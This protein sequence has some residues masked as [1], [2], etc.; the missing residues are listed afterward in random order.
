MEVTETTEPQETFHLF[1]DFPEDIRFLVWE[2][3][4]LDLFHRRPRA[5]DNTVSEHWQ[6]WTANNTTESTGEFGPRASKG[7]QGPTTT[8]PQTPT[9]VLKRKQNL[10]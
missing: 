4:F 1:N 9:T 5:H 6:R 2:Q 8:T 3:A 7:L 10:S